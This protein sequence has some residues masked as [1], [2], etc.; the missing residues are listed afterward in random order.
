ME[1]TILDSAFKFLN[2]G[3]VGIVIGVL[4]SWILF[5]KGKRKA[6]LSAQLSRLTIISP[7]LDEIPNDVKILY[8]G[9]EIKQ[10]NK[11]NIILW[12]CGTETLHGA[13]IVEDSPLCI[14]LLN[15]DNILRFQIVKETRTVNKVRLIA[16]ENN[17]HSINIQFDFLD[18]NDGVNIEIL[19]DSRIDPDIEGTL[20]GMPSGITIVNKKSPSSLIL[21][22]INNA[23]SK[24]VHKIF[25]IIMGFFG[26][27]LLII[28]ILL[29]LDQI[30][31]QQVSAHSFENYMLLA[32][33]LLYFITPFV[34][35]WITRK[36]Y[37][38]C[39]TN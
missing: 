14:S 8:K 27:V 12:N 5:F 9:S 24:L 23:F 35:L 10:L 39:L 11:T 32:I 38:K 31:G 15:G 2:Q 29:E 1:S 18:P 37:P 19:H 25:P 26:L 3:W 16:L 36:R 17:N 4:T 28:Y 34:S 22:E 30:P 13:S 21:K 20:R 7:R 6:M 33:G